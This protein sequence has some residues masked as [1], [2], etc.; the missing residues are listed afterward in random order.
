VCVKNP[1][2]DPSKNVLFQDLMEH[3][4]MDRGDK[5][6]K[7]LT[8]PEIRPDLSYQVGATPEKTEHAREH[9]TLMEELGRDGDDNRPLTL[10]PPEVDLK[11]RYF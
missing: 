2:I 5:F 8:I 7:G 6:Y 4:F 3:Y 9:C 1:N 10:C 11:W